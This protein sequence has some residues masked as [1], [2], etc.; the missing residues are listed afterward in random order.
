MREESDVSLP[1]QEPDNVIILHP[2]VAQIDTDLPKRNPP[3]AEHHAL[4]FRKVLV[5]QVQA[6]TAVASEAGAPATKRPPLSSQARR[7]SL[8][9]S[10]T[11]ANG[12]RPPHRVLQMKSQ[13]RPS[14]TSSSTC[15]TMMRVPLNVGLPWQISGSATMYWPNSSRRDTGRRANELAGNVCSQAGGTPLLPQH[16]KQL[17][18]TPA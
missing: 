7:E 4:V 12:I 13:E 1:A 2:A 5:E 9:A 15:Q 18:S 14:A 8:T 3:P 16:L 11:A 17:F 6:A 10:A